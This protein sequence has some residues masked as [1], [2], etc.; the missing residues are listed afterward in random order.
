MIDYDRLLFAGYLGG[1]VQNHCIVGAAHAIAHQMTDYGY[2]HSEAVALILPTVIRQN[3]E[4]REVL[5]SYDLLA[6]RAG[7][8]SVGDLLSWMH[9]LCEYIGLSEN[10]KKCCELLKEKVQSE[11]FINNVF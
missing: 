5:E 11:N 8:N 7:F 9:K 4:C 2:S 3:S 10:K 1:V 6:R